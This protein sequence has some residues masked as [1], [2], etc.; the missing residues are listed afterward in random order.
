MNHGSWSVLAVPSSNTDGT[1]LVNI[2]NAS[3][4]CLSFN[5]IFVVPKQNLCIT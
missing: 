4:A 3:L 1:T 2:L 5:V